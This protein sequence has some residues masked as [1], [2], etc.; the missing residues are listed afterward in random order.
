MNFEYI[1]AFS[2]KFERHFPPIWALSLF[3]LFSLSLCLSLSLSPSLSLCLPLSLSL[4]LPYKKKRGSH[5][6]EWAGGDLNALGQMVLGVAGS[7]A[8]N[9]AEALQVVHAQRITSKVQHDVL[10]R[11]C[12]AVRKHKAVALEPVR[13]LGRI[14]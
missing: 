8:A 13:V 9:L 2:V 3:S 12:V 10:Q 4:S 1:F 6:S 11:T 5:L 14:L 7:L